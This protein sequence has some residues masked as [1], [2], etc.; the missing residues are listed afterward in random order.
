MKEKL[1]NNLALKVLAIFMSFFVW[2][3]VVNVSNPV[4]TRSQE[5]PVEIINED[6][7]KKAKRTYEITSKNTVTVSYK[8]RIRDAYKVSQSDFRVYADLS[9]LYDITGSI[10]LKVEVINKN[11]KSLLEDTP[12]AKPGVIQIKTEELQRKRFELQYRIGGR[13]EDGYDY[14]NNS[15]IVDPEYVYVSGPVS[16]VGQINSVG[17]EIDAENANHDLTGVAEPV[18]YDA[19]GNALPIGDR[20][21]VNTKDISYTTSIQ[22]VKNLR[23]DF[24]TQ[25]QVAEGYRFI[26]AEGSIQTIPVLGD[27]SVLADINTIKIPAEKLNLRGAAGDMQM[28][29]DL[30]D[31]LPEGVSIQEGVETKMTVTLKVAALKNRTIP[32][33]LNQ[34]ELVGALPN[35]AYTFD[36]A[37]IDVVIRGLE[38]EVSKVSLNDLNLSIDVSNLANGVYKGILNYNVGEG[39]EVTSYGSFSISAAPKDDP[40]A[41]SEETQTAGESEAESETETEAEVESESETETESSQHEPVTIENTEE[42]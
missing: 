29:V 11:I 4:K 30:A 7:L 1:T 18:F 21:E 40:A 17:I 15:T 39:Y 5:I 38:K 42:N 12:E 26:G 27:A 3:I 19:N 6:I 33:R 34:V 36:P 9:E 22:K 16:L 31:Y 37:T 32:V 14:G 8:I 24:E 35:W 23:I 20:I 10:P 41:S 13:P 2:L 25:G 28:V